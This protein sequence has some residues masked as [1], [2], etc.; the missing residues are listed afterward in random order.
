MEANEIRVGNLL[1]DPRKFNKDTR[2][3]FN[4]NEN[5]YFKA[6]AR[7]I[8]CAELFNP[9]PLTEEILL[10]CGFEYNDD[11]GKYEISDDDYCIL[12]RKDTDTEEFYFEI[13]DLGYNYVFKTIKYLH[14]L[15]NIF[16]CLVGEELKVNL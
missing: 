8:Q 10:K 15:Q 11:I 14:E 3:F 7:D 9:I 13:G 4:I 1:I 5:G 12:I 6:T 16:W 2:E